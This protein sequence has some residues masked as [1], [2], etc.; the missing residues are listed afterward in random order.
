[1]IDTQA[2][3]YKTYEGWK[4]FCHTNAV[5]AF[6]SDAK[7]DAISITNQ[8]YSTEYTLTLKDQWIAE[9]CMV[10]AFLSEDFKPVIQVE[11]KPV[12]AGSKGGADIQHGGITA[13]PVADYY[14]EP[15]ATAAP[16]DYSAAL[17][18]TRQGSLLFPRG[19]I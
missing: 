14:P 5:R 15:S 7:G 12:V 8:R 10:V 3:Y 4:E 19:T 17:L 2:D 11:Q 1:M 16:S 13:V 9:N 6:L 18:F